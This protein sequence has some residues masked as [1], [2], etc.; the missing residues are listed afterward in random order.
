MGNRQHH[1]GTITHPHTSS[2]AQWFET[3]CLFRPEQSLHPQDQGTACVKVDASGFEPERTHQHSGAAE[4]GL[5]EL[6]AHVRGGR[7][8]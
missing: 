4:R 2:H 7:G 3:R 5:G 6:R 1:P 8:E